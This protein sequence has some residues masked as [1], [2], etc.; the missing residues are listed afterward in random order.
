MRDLHARRA[1]AGK[2]L[3]YIPDPAAAKHGAAVKER[4]DNSREAYADQDRTF[5]RGQGALARNLTTSST[6]SSSSKSPNA[7]TSGRSAVE[8]PGALDAAV[9]DQRRGEDPA[10]GPHGLACSGPRIRLRSRWPSRKE[11]NIG[12]RRTCGGAGSSRA[13]PTRSGRAPRPPRARAP[14]RRGAP[15]ASPAPTRPRSPRAPTAG[16]RGR[17]GG[18]ARRRGSVGLRP[19]GPSQSSMR[20][21]SL[22]RPLDDLALQRGDAGQPGRHLRV[23]GQVDAARPHRLGELAGG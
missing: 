4:T 20:T 7:V 23:V 16:A 13:G 11:S 22:V 9:D 1:H 10:A 18:R 2:L 5:T 19:A 15:R 17:G 8:L 12:S 3:D 6:S 21:N 14:R